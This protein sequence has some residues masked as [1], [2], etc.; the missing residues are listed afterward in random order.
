MKLHII[1]NVIVY[2]YHGFFEV[3]LFLIKRKSTQGQ[4]LNLKFCLKIIN[5]ETLPWPMVLLSLDQI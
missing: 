4:T 2:V 3:F 1:V 5:A